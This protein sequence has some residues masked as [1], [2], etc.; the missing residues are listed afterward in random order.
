M[1]FEVY[2]KLSELVR[3]R[4][5]N[6]PKSAESFGT[7]VSSI[8]AALSEGSKARVISEKDRKILCSTFHNAAILESSE[9]RLL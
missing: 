6:I 1:V 5:L 9:G 2:R 7:E 4:P 8:Y 3:L